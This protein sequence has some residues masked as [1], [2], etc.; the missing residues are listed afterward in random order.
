MMLAFESGRLWRML[1]CL[2]A[3]A[4]SLLIPAIA[5]AQTPPATDDAPAPAPEP[6]EPSS[7]MNLTGDSPTIDLSTPPPPAPVGRKY[8]QHDGF[9]VRVSGGI[10]ALLGASADVGDVSFSSGGASLDIEAL[11]GGSPA[12]GFSIGGGVLGSLQL[13]G[14][15]ELDNG[16]GTDSAD[17]TSII[18]GPFADGYPAPNGGWHFGGLLGLASVSFQQPGGDDGSNAIGV[19]GAVWT[20]YDIWVAPEWS[21]GGSL[22]FDAFRATNSDDDLTISKIGGTLSFSVLYN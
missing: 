7:H 16:V 9:Y 3:G 8:H 18:I 10:G 22:Q 20:G 6:A 21:V 15:W 12:P 17:L 19:G 2:A 14:D 13:S 4:C 11:V 1:G 5:V